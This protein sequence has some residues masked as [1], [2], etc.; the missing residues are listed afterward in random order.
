[1]P[2]STLRDAAIRAAVSWHSSSRTSTR[3]ADAVS[4]VEYLDRSHVEII[5]E[6]RRRLQPNDLFIAMGAGDVHEIAEAL[7]RGAA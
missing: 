2:R 5:D 3:A 1:V 6:L 7:V 4:G